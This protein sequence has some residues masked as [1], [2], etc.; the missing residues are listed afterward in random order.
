LFRF[1]RRTA[2]VPIAAIVWI[3]GLFPAAPARAQLVARFE[4]ANVVFSPDQD[5]VE[6]TTGIYFT[7]SEASPEV[8]VVAVAADSVTPVDTLLSPQSRPSGRTDV[9]WNGRAWDGTPVADGG[10]IV[11]LAAKGTTEPDSTARRAV[12]VD[13]GAPSIVVDSVTP[14]VYAPGVVGQ[15]SSL[16]VAFTVSGTTPPLA[17]IPRDEVQSTFVQPG[18]AT[19]TPDSLSFY[20]AYS[21]NDGSYELRWHASKAT[22]IASGEWEV[23]LTIVDQAGHSQSSSHAFEVDAKAPDL[24]VLSPVTGSSFRQ[25]PALMH[26]WAHDASGVKA[27]DIKYADAEAYVAVTD[28]ATVNDTLFF[29]APLADSLA[30]EGKYKITVRATDIFGRTAAV[31]TD[32]TIDRSSPQAPVLDPFSGPWHTNTFRVTGS[33]KK[34]EG[35]ALARIRI[36][37]GGDAVDSLFTLPIDKGHPVFDRLITLVPGHN[38][39]RAYYVDGAGNV[40]PPSNG[41]EVTFDVAVGLFITAPFSPGDQFQVTLARPAQGLALRLY[42]MTGDLV[43]VIRDTGADISY[44]LPWNGRNGD[45]EPVRKG[46]LVAVA[47]ASFEDG[48]HEIYRELFLFEPYPK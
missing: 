38:D 34:E 3:A 22:G 10:Y 5:G 8:S 11:M 4:V 6:E 42:D 35:D 25:A 41:I 44:A 29:D 18:G 9:S 36:V 12:F 26:G 1:T 15:P 24:K 2:L 7:L 19:Y 16:V 30:A 48:G 13:T 14:G 23:R 20:P 43:A 37:R 33:F 31:S 40:S 27:I 17:G 32:I 39:I 21:G 47:E 46:P 45:G 28:T